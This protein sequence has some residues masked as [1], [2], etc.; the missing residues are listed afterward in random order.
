MLRILINNTFLNEICG[1]ILGSEARFF[2]SLLLL[3]LVAAG[4]LL[5]V[6]LHISKHLNLKRYTF[7]S[8]TS[9]PQ[10]KTT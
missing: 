1:H 7:F 4:L 9:H 6:I 5:A 2:K 10:I 3:M 8:Y